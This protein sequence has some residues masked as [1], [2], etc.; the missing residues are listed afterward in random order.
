MVTAVH[1]EGGWV[2]LAAWGEIDSEDG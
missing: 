1:E 2:M